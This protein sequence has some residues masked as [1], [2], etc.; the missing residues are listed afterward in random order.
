MYTRARLFVCL[1]NSKYLCRF[2]HAPLLFC[3]VSARRR[4]RVNLDNY[5]FDSWPRNLSAHA[6]SYADIHREI[7]SEIEIY[8]LAE[9]GTCAVNVSHRNV[10]LSCTCVIEF[11][12]NLSFHKFI[13]IVFSW[14][15]KWLI[16]INA[17]R[18][19]LFL[20]CRSSCR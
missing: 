2:S 17:Q 18:K 11:S 19:I 3:G 6:Q 20:E 15:T 8:R 5:G 1:T 13:Q 9:R 16:R 14:N 7:S 12:E 10:S 4:I